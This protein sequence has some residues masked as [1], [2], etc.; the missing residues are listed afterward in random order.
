MWKQAML[1][2]RRNCKVNKP[3]VW[4]S[5]AVHSCFYPSC[6]IPLFGWSVYS[7]SWAWRIKKEFP[8][9]WAFVD[10]TLFVWMPMAMSVDGSN[11]TSKFQ[12]SFLCNVADS[13]NIVDNVVIDPGTL[14]YLMIAACVIWYV[15]CS[16]F[17]GWVHKLGVSLLRQWLLEFKL[18]GCND[19]HSLQSLFTLYKGSDRKHSLLASTLQERRRSVIQYNYWAWI[20]TKVLIQQ[21]VQQKE[22][23]H[24]HLHV[25]KRL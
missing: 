9:R 3:M 11:E 1:G 4:D 22:S 23:S 20:S 8:D 10:Y 15:I 18:T 19:R 21:F 24:F 17:F 14:K 6:S 16:Q 12:L 2:E 7:D 5:I 25:E 13:L